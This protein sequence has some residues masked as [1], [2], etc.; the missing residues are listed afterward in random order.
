MLIA[1]LVAVV[2]TPGDW[3][4]RA[5]PDA[6]PAHTEP[7]RDAARGPPLDPRLT[8]RAP[9]DFGSGLALAP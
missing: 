5:L 6:R 1:V 3:S 4:W 9:P 8:L 2:P 7:P